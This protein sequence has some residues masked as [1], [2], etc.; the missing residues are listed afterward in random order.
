MNQI[1]SF[2]SLAKESA[3]AY[4]LVILLWS[5]LFTD[6]VRMRQ[7]ELRFLWGTDVRNDKSACC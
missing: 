5:V 7:A 1:A 3:A 2:T 6:K 4:T